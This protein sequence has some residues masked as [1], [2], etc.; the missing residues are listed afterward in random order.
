MFSRRRFFKAL[1]MSLAAGAAGSAQALSSDSAVAERTT[2]SMGTVVGF[3]VYGPEASKAEAWLDA[4]DSEMERLASELTVHAEKSPLLEV[5]RRSGEAVAVPDDVYEAMAAALQ[6]ARE[7]GSAFEP[8]IG[9]LVDVWKIGFG[10]D[11]VPSELEIRRALQFVDWRRVQ[12]ARKGG[13]AFIQIGKGQDV[14][15]GG[16]AKGYIGTKLAA[17]LK[18]LGARKALLN[19]GGNIVLVGSAP[20]GQPW[21][22]GLQHP[23]EERNDYFAV[24]EAEDESVITSGAYERKIEV[25][26]KEYG[27][28][29][30]PLTGHPVSTDLSSVS[31]ADRDG[32]KADAWCTAFFAMGREKAE[33]LLA[34]RRDIEAV[35]MSKD[36]RTVWMTPGIAKRCQVTDSS[37]KDVLIIQR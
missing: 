25:K 21:K 26:G 28:I 36:C 17:Y 14:D 9:K 32:A 23:D 3:R 5:M 34:S 10:G 33:K 20:S 1:A 4:A 37:V 29:L 24:L 7:S 30:S 2:F 11:V 16:I 19:L 15:L 27:H 35:L 8:T 18:G 13:Q 31:I 6:V 12:L 22:I